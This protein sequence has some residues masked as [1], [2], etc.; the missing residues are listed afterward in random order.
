MRKYY[1]KKP[2]I[3]LGPDMRSMISYLH[4]SDYNLIVFVEEFTALCNNTKTLQKVKV[5]RC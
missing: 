3:P 2:H 1:K 4:D 5:K